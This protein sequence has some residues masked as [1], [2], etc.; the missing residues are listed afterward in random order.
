MHTTRTRGNKVVPNSHLITLLP[1]EYE[2]QIMLLDDD[3]VCAV[4]DK[5][6]T[7]AFTVYNQAAAAQ[8]SSESLRQS[9]D[10]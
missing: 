1:L 7:S 2:F 5:A 3:S 8:P 6:P 10:K 4:E 9:T